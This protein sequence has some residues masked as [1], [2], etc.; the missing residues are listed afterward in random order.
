[1]EVDDCL[2]SH[3]KLLDMLFEFYSKYDHIMRGGVAIK[4]KS[5]SYSL[6][7][8][9]NMLND[10]SLISGTSGGG[11]PWG[12]QLSQRD[13]RLAFFLARFTVVDEVKHR[14]RLMSMDRLELFEAVVRC[15]ELLADELPLQA[16][17]DKVKAADILEYESILIRQ[18]KADSGSSG[19][20]GG[21]GGGIVAEMAKQQRGEMLRNR[22][23]HERLEMFVRVLAGR[24]AVRYKGRIQHGKSIVAL[25]PRYV[26]K[27]DHLKLVQ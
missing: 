5:K 6:E 19:G 16:D 3:V 22:K 25:I 14:G 26:A 21:D 18:Q 7:S 17:L 11:A 27:S 15:A 12:K 8:W 9:M 2:K 4:S 10:A 20:G 1:M 24:L 23:L 13:A